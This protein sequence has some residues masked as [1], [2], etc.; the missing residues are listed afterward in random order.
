MEKVSCVACGRLQAPFLYAADMR[1]VIVC[2]RIKSI[3]FSNVTYH[4]MVTKN[5]VISYVICWTL[6]GTTIHHFYHT[7]L[8]PHHW[9]LSLAYVAS[10]FAE[11]FLYLLPKIYLLVLQFPPD[12][13][14]DNI[15]LGGL[16]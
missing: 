13:L 4:I 3:F 7:A 10:F 6:K 16:A 5:V 1:I 8:R 15:C 12:A 2:I 11:A 14:R 9:P